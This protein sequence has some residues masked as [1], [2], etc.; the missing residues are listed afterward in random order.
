MAV[1]Q[2]PIHQII[3]MIAVWHGFV[4][5]ARPV[6]MGTVGG[7]MAAIGIG[8]TDSDHMLVHMIAVRMV[9]M[10]IVQIIGVAIVADRRVATARPVHMVVAGMNSAAHE[11]MSLARMLRTHA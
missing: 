2:A 8:G 9:E 11:V 3:D 4:A 10:A 5:A 6:H 1:V 7:G